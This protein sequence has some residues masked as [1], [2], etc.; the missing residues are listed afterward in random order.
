MEVALCRSAEGQ[1]RSMGA[2]QNR[3]GWDGVL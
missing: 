3:C 1:P 2:H